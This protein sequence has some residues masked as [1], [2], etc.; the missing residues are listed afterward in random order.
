MKKTGRIDAAIFKNVGDMV[1]KQQTTRRML[2]NPLK[3][4][5]F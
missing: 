5:S 4:F 3:M 1:W 2:V